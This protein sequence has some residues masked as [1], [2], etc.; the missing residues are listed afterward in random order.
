MATRASFEAVANIKFRIGW[1][2]P[3]YDRADV[4]QSGTTGRSESM[5][6]YVIVTPAI[7]AERLRLGGPVDT[8][9]RVGIH[10]AVDFGTLNGGYRCSGAYLLRKRGIVRTRS[11]AFNAT[12]Q[13]PCRSYVLYAQITCAIKTLAGFGGFA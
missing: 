12:L 7:A 8:K 9:R 4:R 1:T 5:P 6:A 10:R 11:A 13:P 2:A 3:Q